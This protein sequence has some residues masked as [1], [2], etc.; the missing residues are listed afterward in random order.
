MDAEVDVAPVVLHPYARAVHQFV[1]RRHNAE[2]PT[3]QQL[4]ESLGKEAAAAPVTASSKFGELVAG[5]GGRLSL[6]LPSPAHHCPVCC[7]F[8]TASRV[9]CT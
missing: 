3:L 5:L 2:H 1:Q 4:L 6:P 8:A 7:A 9:A